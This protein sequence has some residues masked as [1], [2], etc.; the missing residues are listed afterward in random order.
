M[1]DT[2][3][4]G[5][6]FRVWLRRRA[7]PGAPY[8]VRFEV[9]DG[10][11]ILRVAR[12]GVLVDP[13]AR[14]FGFEERLS[15]AQVR[16]SRF[17]H[18]WDGGRYRQ[19]YML[20]RLEEARME[21]LP[22]DRWIQLEPSNFG[23][24]SALLLPALIGPTT[25]EV[26]DEPTWPRREGT[27]DAALAASVAPQD[28]AAHT[29]AAEPERARP[30]ES[31][32]PRPVRPIY[33]DGPRPEQRSAPARG[34]SPFETLDSWLESSSVNE[35]DRT[36]VM[37]GS[38]LSAV[39][40]V[41]TRP[42]AFPGLLP[43]GASDPNDERTLIEAFDEESA[44]EAGFDEEEAL[45]AGDED[46]DPDAIPAL[47]D[48]SEEVPRR[49]VTVLPDAPPEPS[50]PKFASASA[51]AVSPAASASA[52][53]ASA[54]SASAASASMSASVDT[55]EHTLHE[56]N[57]TLVRHLRR[58]IARD[59]VHIASLEHRIRLLEAEL[60]RRR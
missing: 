34:A 44:L 1:P 42:S 41:K 55:G 25:G 19:G 37:T 5:G 51:S 20:A 46:D 15:A 2:E 12:P 4:G 24:N 17:L 23:V 9:T 58:E 6:R 33:S 50:R 59:R 39:S 52:A 43:F 35:E 56:R 60:S 48:L 32:A 3:T 28:A 7:E 45:E 16:A 31:E 47:D 53:S 57:T 36:Q 54:A 8:S 49:I 29:L 27:L 21:A 14:P 38:S 10:K 30:S 13:P 11:G 40:R 18:V 22:P 26:D